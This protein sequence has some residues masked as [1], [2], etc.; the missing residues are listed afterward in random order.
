M[1]KNTFI[2]LKQ[3][4]IQLYLTKLTVDELI[5]NCEVQ[6]F[7]S[8]TEDGY[9]RP[10]IPSHYKR[11]AQYLNKEE[12]PLLPLGILTAVYPDNVKE[13]E[14]HELRLTENLRIVDGQHRVEGFRYLAMTNQEKYMELKDFE[15]PVTIMVISKEEI[16]T[17]ID[18]FINI[19]SKGKKLST[20]LAIRLRH[21]RRKRDDYVR[22]Y[23]E[24]VEDI[25]IEVTKK[26]N[27]DLNSLW[28][29]AIKISPEQKGTIISLNAFRKSLIPI[30]EKYVNYYVDPV[31]IGDA[32]YLRIPEETI[33]QREDI[34]P[35]LEEH[36]VEYVEKIKN[37]I[38]KVW[39]IV[40]DKWPECFNIGRPFF[41]KEYNIQKG[42]GVYSIH[43]ILLDCMN[44]EGDPEAGYYKFKELINHTDIQTEDWESGGMFSG[45]N[46]QS[47]FRYIANTVTQSKVRND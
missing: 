32:T 16:T 29:K 11:I 21:Q 45:N 6:T 42:I 7:N 43:L 33:A 3:K 5:K 15:V 38:Q 13:T 2:P 44:S 31:N 17:E 26:L 9:Q 22:T 30:V 18:T 39:L 12:E 24:I 37:Y 1:I 10:P 47:G 8:E 40:R 41:D 4:G 36:E 19:N 27:K 14:D 28:T 20:D 46:S 23:D 34:S 35:V 25:A